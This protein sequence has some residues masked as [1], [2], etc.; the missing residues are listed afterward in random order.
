MHKKYEML[1]DDT[2]EVNGHTLHRIRAVRFIKNIFRD[3]QPGTLGGYIEKEE[4]LSQEG[5]CWVYPDTRILGDAKVTG[6]TIVCGNTVVFTGFL[7]S[8]CYYT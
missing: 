2:I 3:I 7:K 8:G 5:N 6:N 1:S 4:N